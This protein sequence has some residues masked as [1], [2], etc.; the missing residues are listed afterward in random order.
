MSDS[1]NSIYKQKT[2]KGFV[3]LMNDD[4]PI[5][6]ALNHGPTINGVR[7]NFD[8]VSRATVFRSKKQAMAVLRNY[9]RDV[10]LKVIKKIYKIVPLKDVAV[11]QIEVGGNFK[12]FNKVTPKD[13][14]VPAK[15]RVKAL[16][17]ESQ[18]LTE[19]AQKLL[20]EAKRVLKQAEILSKVQE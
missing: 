15:S 7:W 12:I 9:D 1:R 19:E 13:H 5:R 4:S 16:K 10:S 3:V 20:S 8:W 2:L 6:L 18:L 11:L 17:E 14:A